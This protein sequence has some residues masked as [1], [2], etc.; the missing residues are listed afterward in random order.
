MVFFF[1]RCD[2]RAPE[3]SKNKNAA[4]KKLP[5]GTLE[6]EF[7][8]PRG[9]VCCLERK[10]TKEYFTLLSL[11]GKQKNAKIHKTHY[12]RSCGSERFLCIAQALR[13]SYLHMPRT[14]HTS[15]AVRHT[16][17]HTSASDAQLPLDSFIN[18]FAPPCRQLALP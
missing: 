13:P 10:N 9:S 1:L 8:L 12:L 7:H 6:K 18:Q 17:R 16:T 3:E 2:G 11:K 4:K 14:C 5:S 15:K